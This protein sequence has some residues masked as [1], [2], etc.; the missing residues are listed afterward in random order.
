MKPSFK[1]SALFGSLL[2][3]FFLAV[4]PSRIAAQPS[5]YCP[6]YPP[7]IPS[8][9]SYTYTY[10]YGPLYYGYLINVKI[11][12][13]T[14]GQWVLD[15]T[16]G[17]DNCYT[18]TGQEAKLKLGKSY[19]LYFSFYMP[20]SYYCQ[21]ITQYSYYYYC[22]GLAWLDWNMNAKFSDPNEFLGVQTLDLANWNQSTCTGTYGPFNI[23]VPN[24]QQVGKTRLRVAHNMWRHYGGPGSTG[25]YLYYLWDYPPYY[26]YYYAYGEAEDY[27]IEFM[28]DIEATFPNDGDILRANETYDG[29]DANHPRPMVRMGST[30]PS[31][32]ILRY[33]I[34]GPKPSTNVVYEGLDPATGSIDINMGGYRQY[35][36]QR[37]RGTFAT[38]NGGFRAN[39]GGEYRLQV[40][41]GGTAAPA[42]AY[43]NFTVAWDNDL[44]ITGVVSPRTNLPP[45]FMKYL[46][47]QTIR[48]I[49]TFQNTGLNNITEF[50]ANARIVDP[51][52]V[53][54][55]NRQV[56]F[57]ANNDPRYSPLQPGQKIDM[58]FPSFQGTVVGV[59]KLYLDCSLESAVDQEAYNNYLPRQDEGDYTFEIAYEFQVKANRVVKPALNEQIIGNRPYIPSGEFKNL[60]VNVASDFP[61]RLIL[62]KLP[63]TLNSVYQ[64]TITVQDIQSGTYNTRVVDFDV[65]IP[66]ETGQYLAKLICAHPEDPV[67]S[68]DTVWSYFSVLGGLAGTYR[69]GVGQDFPTIDSAMNALYLR[70]VSGNV[71]FEL[72]DSY[73]QV[74]ARTDVEPSAPAW[75]FRSWILNLGYNA[76]LNTTYTVT[77]K[78][79]TQKSLTKG[80]ITIELVSPTG[81]GIAFGQTTKPSNVYSV[82]YEYRTK[83]S[84]SRKYVNTPGYIIFD[85]GPQKSIKLRLVSY[86]RGGGQAIYL[87]PGSHHIQI[88]NLIIENANSNIADKTWLPM[89]AYSPVY[90]FT[91]TP[92]TLLQGS[93]VFGYSAGVTIR[94]YLPYDN[95]EREQASI[96]GLD[97]LPANN[98]LIEG[99]E[100]YGFGYGI[101]SIGYGQLW[102][103]TNYVK[104]YNYNNT[105]SN[106]T[107]YNVKR[108]GIFLGYEQNS[109]VV[110]NRI[111]NVNGG[112]T[113]AYGILLGGEGSSSYKGY[114]N[115][116]ISINR[117]EISGVS[118]NIGAIG[119]KVEQE[120]NVLPH[121]YLGNVLY[122]DVAESMQIANNI[123]WGVT[124]GTGNAYRAGIH[125]MTARQPNPDILAYFLTP[126]ITGYYSRN[127]KIVNNTI[128]ISPNPGV[129]SAYPIAG[130]GIQHA[131]NTLVMNNAVAL[132]DM[133]VD[134]NNQVYACLFYQGMM[135]S[136]MGLTS[137]RNAFW[138]A[139]GSGGTVVRFVE[140]DENDNILDN[141]GNRNDF[142]TLEQ[143]QNW[144]GMDANSVFGNFTNDF[145]YQGYAPNQKLRIATNPTPLGSILNNRGNRIDW[146]THDI[147]GNIRGAAGQRYDIGAVEFDGRLYLSDLEMIKITYPAKYQSSTGMFNDAQYV[148]DNSPT[149]VKALVRNS[150]NLQQSAVNVTVNIYREMPDGNFSTVPEV[151]ATKQ[152]TLSSG[153]S[154]EV[155]FALNDGQ[156]PDFKPKTYGELA[157][158]GYYVPDQF[159]TMQANVT[160]RYKI[161]VSLGGD[162]QNANNSVSKVVRYYIPQSKT[163]ALL[164]VENSMVQLDANST[165]DEIAGRLNYDSLIT[166]FRKLGWMIDIP[167]GIFDFDIFD[168]KGWEPKAVDYTLFNSI[169]WADGDDKPLTKMEK[170][171]LRRFLTSGTVEAKKNLVISSQ[172]IVRANASD[173]E[174]VGGLLRAKNVA[175][176][177]PQGAGV[178]NDGNAVIGL[179]VG[180]KLA[181][182]IRSTGYNGDVPP[183][184]GLMAVEA[185]GAG[186]ALA[187][188]Y[189]RSHQGSTTDSIAGVATTTLTRNV[190]LFGVDWRHWGRIDMI[191]RAILD[192]ANANGG[193]IIPVE[194]SEFNAKPVGNVVYVTWA[195]ESEYNTSKFEVERAEV[196]GATKSEFVKVGEEKAAGTSTSRK[197]YGPV[198]DRGVGFGKVYVYRLKV[199][200][201][202]GATSYSREV[203][204]KMEGEVNWVSEV[205]PNPS[206][207]E[208]KFEVSAI[209]GA[210]IEARIIDLAGRE[211]K[212]VYNGVGNGNVVKVVANVSDL[213]SGMYTLVV[214]IGNETITRSVNIVR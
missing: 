118:S 36:I 194:L 169:L 24:S 16:T 78:P 64:S 15:W 41:I 167:E 138:Y 63:D 143:W 136:E 58:E 150:G 214:K 73:Y 175:P 178:S 190:I 114:N 153:E 71:V 98:N 148:M 147:D 125:L 119:I 149:N 18:F 201:V 37:A 34:V 199:V 57:D 184:C 66:R 60:G 206:D 126:K 127:D 110:G 124:V 102:R 92:D 180:R 72:T 208:V 108:A 189:Y 137:D 4:L 62:Y 33:R 96:M 88:K 188:G 161:V 172:E 56:H 45:R 80:S 28:P 8:G 187:G 159:L 158:E 6:V 111:Y 3:A 203:M 51:N 105:F 122:P 12:D 65:F 210:N 200:D 123:I 130:I 170:I 40:T 14:T 48:V 186:Q 182:S 54:V 141:G 89:T 212:R 67:R 23:N 128:V 193:F 107:I 85:G 145:V 196:Q 120:A 157:N 99:N 101:V 17:A 213:P 84:I 204:V 163:R 81:K 146:V 134:P 113:D 179:A 22:Y 9:Y 174:F 87:G 135:P 183:Y 142:A 156:A 94:S 91:Y 211:V 59:Y 61:V 100:I 44:S 152:V 27:V 131:K 83:G 76:D 38:S 13:V 121:P 166:A 49:G 32:A 55:Y 79:S 192:F 10:C 35:N 7:D 26:F 5:G 47:G 103:E 168:R 109:Q 46:R 177:N 52:G 86:S 176:G 132:M 154:I 197:E 93:N 173:A 106:N 139:N 74:K 116:G 185:N 191:I 29:S 25:C 43:P 155:D 104:Y 209:E 207:N 19:Q 97:T 181:M 2:L 205:M 30:Q 140:T 82:Y 50:Y 95:L 42:E 70:G 39:R 195:T 129:V 115:I 165:V 68:D 160:P 31:G 198:V 11:K 69:V 117:N 75:D 20:Y 151:T 53:E 77:W 144:T 171:D 112:S 202:D 164:S 90:G 21:Y 1:L 133:N 162:Q